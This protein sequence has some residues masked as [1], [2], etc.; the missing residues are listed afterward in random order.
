MR[1]LCRWM[2]LIL[3]SWAGV[4][5]GT[6]ILRP[7]LAPRTF[8]TVAGFA[9]LDEDVYSADM[10]A[11]AE[12]A[13]TDWLS[14]YVDGAFR[15][16]SYS[17]E[18]SLRDG[19]LHNYANLHVNGFNETYVGAKLM[20]PRPLLKNSGV[21]LGWRIPPGEGSQRNRF[22][23]LNVEPF[24]LYNLSRNLLLGTAFRYNMFLEES[25]YKTG[26]EV[27]FRMSLVWRPFWKEADL[28]GWLV[29]ETFLY[30]KRIA[31][32]ENRNLKTP[33]RKMDDNY[34]GVKMSVD[35]GYRFAGFK[36]GLN[37]VPLTLGLNYEMHVGTLFG[38]E[39]GHRLGFFATAN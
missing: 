4:A 11:S 7:V 35:V 2:F 21:N 16:F 26:D 29:S 5:W 13:L 37:Y 1:R 30:Q 34:Q 39:T 33:Y 38:F 31:E 23:R 20:V 24:T 3:G 27:G 10:V 14:I 6:E 32:S 25:S 17:Y 8:V 36:Y 15:F 9:E 12:Y 18:Y 22:H 19:Y 28:S